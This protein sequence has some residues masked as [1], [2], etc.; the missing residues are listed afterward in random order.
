MSVALAGVHAGAT[1][2]P[3]TPAAIARRLN[4]ASSTI[5]TLFYSC[6]RLQIHDHAFVSR[7][8]SPAQPAPPCR[9]VQAAVSAMRVVRVQLYVFLARQ[10]KADKVKQFGYG[11]Q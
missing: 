7:G 6:L 8:K 10:L 3:T 5:E 11:H 2:P 9:L 4:M 1:V